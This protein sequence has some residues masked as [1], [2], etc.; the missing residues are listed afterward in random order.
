MS[1]KHH[2]IPVW[3]FVG[4]LLLIYGVLILASG[5]IGWSHPPE[6]VV[7][8]NL[9]APVWWGAVLIVLGVVYCA[10]FRPGKNT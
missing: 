10:M 5:L 8:T 1:E 3:F 7:L 2:I 4:C 6:N 9:H